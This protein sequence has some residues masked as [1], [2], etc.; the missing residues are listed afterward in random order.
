M[1][2]CNLFR[3]GYCIAAVRVCV[4]ASSLGYFRIQ[5]KSL[6]ECLS[7][8]VQLFAMVKYNTHLLS[9]KLVKHLL[10]DRKTNNIFNRNFFTTWQLR[11]LTPFCETKANINSLN[12]QFDLFSD[13]NFVKV[14]NKYYIAIII[15]RISKVKISK[16]RLETKIIPSHENRQPNF[17][18]NF[19]YY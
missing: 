18:H 16:G 7:N 14:R 3:K 6:H 13:L 4:C 19:S 12:Q 1:T 2:S 9:S 15:R 8:F 10:Q 5:R 11:L 17:G